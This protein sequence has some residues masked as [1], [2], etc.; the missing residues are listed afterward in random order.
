MNGFIMGWIV[1]EIGIGLYRL[2]VGK[3]GLDRDSYFEFKAEK[4]VEYGRTRKPGK[5]MRAKCLLIIV[6]V[7][8]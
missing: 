3:M 6:I 8:E 4:V 7:F 1:E 5:F 2:I